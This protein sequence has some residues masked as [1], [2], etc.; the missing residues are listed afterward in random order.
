[1]GGAAAAGAPVPVSPGQL[2]LTLDVNVV[3]GIK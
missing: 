2:V 3:F 1:V